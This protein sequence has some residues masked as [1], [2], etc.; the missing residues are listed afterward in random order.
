MSDGLVP[1]I[2]LFAGEQ[3]KMNF[4]NSE[5]AMS[6]I[7][8]TALGF[9][10][11]CSASSLHYNIPLWYSA[12]GDYDVIDSTHPRLK[13][14]RVAGSGVS[15]VSVIEIHC[16]ELERA[17][18]ECLKLNFGVTVSS[19]Q[20]NSDP[21]SLLE[22]PCPDSAK[23]RVSF[24]GLEN[25][26][27][28]TVSYS[29]VIPS[30]QDPNSVFVGW[31]TAGFRYIQS[32]FQNKEQPNYQDIQY[33]QQVKIVQQRTHGDPASVASYSTAFMVCLAELLPCSSMPLRLPLPVQ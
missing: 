19:D 3:A 23:E 26:P 1:A 15:E 13:E 11:L 5:E 30:G 32:Q 10:P 33:G 4:G 21:C 28:N 18:Q 14:K 7:F 9:Q 17:R 12:P 20:A 27:S 22:Q 2:T 16:S 6:C 24:K 29:V 8:A 25:Q 31:T